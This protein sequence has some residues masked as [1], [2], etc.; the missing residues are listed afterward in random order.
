ML[1]VVIVIIVD[2]FQITIDQ[3]K[4]SMMFVFTIYSFKDKRKNNKM[5]L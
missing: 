5:I 1:L 4:H 2:D 3:L